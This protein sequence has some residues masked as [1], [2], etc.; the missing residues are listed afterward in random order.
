MGKIASLVKLADD[1][2]QTGKSAI[3]PNPC[4]LHISK[5][6]ASGNWPG[7]HLAQGFWLSRH[8]R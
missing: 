6:E 5:C 4:N 1:L 2:R 8:R 7:N 3:C